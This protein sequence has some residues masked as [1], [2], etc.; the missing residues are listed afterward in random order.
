MLV[1]VNS[2]ASTRYESLSPLVAGALNCPKVGRTIPIA[3]ISSPDQKEIYTKLSYSQLKKS[4]M[5]SLTSKIVKKAL[6]GEVP[7]ADATVVPM[8]HLKKSRRY[9]S[10]TFVQLDEGES[11]TIA[12]KKSG[13]SQKIPLSHLSEGAQAY[14]KLM[15]LQ[16]TG[17]SA[18]GGSEE[19]NTS[20]TVETW[21]S[22]KDGKK[23]KATFISLSDGQ[24][25]LKKDNGKS[26]TF[27]LTKLSDKS[28][29]RA[30]ELSEN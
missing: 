23:M 13:G 5:Y 22:S 2:K 28:Q 24:I 21:E 9:C 10:G 26:I 8:W 18:D 29:Q 25:T 17:A 16:R 12:S 6:K 30:K 19:K 1:Y 20:H 11:L 4:K 15:E 14:A 27:P 7:P 3:V